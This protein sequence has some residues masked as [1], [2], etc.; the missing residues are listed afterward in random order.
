MEG[1]NLTDLVFFS[2]QSVLFLFIKIF[3][4]DL[5][6]GYHTQQWTVLNQS[7]QFYN[8]INLTVD[9]STS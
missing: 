5:A 1:I 9:L 2:A 6:G 4:S 8:L 3:F 7:V